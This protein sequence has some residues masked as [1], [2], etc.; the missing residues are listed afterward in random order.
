MGKLADAF[1]VLCGTSILSCLFFSYTSADELLFDNTASSAEYA[2]N[3]VG[4][5]QMWN[6]GG[7][8]CSLV[9]DWNVTRIVV[10]VRRAPT[11]IFNFI[12]GAQIVHGGGFNTYN[13]QNTTIAQQTYSTTST[14]FADY[15]FTWATPQNLR[16]LCEAHGD[17]TPIG[18][19]FIRSGGSGA[20]RTKTVADAADGLFHNGGGEDPTKDLAM[21]VYGIPPAPPPPA[22]PDPVII[23]SGILG[24]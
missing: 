11:P 23:I 15:E 12:F 4:G 3:V 5:Y 8:S 1:F 17:T 9:P 16:A 13:G 19:G 22:A 14:A 18:L 7:I 21:K 10:S 24:S 2:Q 20:A 6:N